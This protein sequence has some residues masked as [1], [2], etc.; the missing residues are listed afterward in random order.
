M[1]SLPVSAQLWEVVQGLKTG[2]RV[3]IVDTAGQEHKGLFAGA[4]PAAISVETAKGQEAIE[5]PQVRRVQVRSRSRRVR[6]VLI[7]VAIGVAVGVV[8]DQT[9]GTYLRNESGESGG[10][11][12]VSYVAPIALFGGIGAALPGWRTVYRVR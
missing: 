6:N 9:A 3:A 8:V 10:T 11:R 7:G 5:R 1:F 2:D 12:A 4:S